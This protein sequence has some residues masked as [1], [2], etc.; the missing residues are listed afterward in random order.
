[1]ST[2]SGGVGG[3][4]TD[5]T[6]TSNDLSDLNHII[7][8]DT[9]GPDCHRITVNAAGTLVSTPVNC[10]TGPALPAFDNF[11]SYSA[12]DLTGANGGSG[13]SE[14]WQGGGHATFQV[15]TS[16]C[17]FGSCIKGSGG[18]VM[19][20]DRHFATTMSNGTLTFK[21]KTIIGG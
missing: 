12:G 3:T 18:S 9:D 13:W 14:A 11:D 4:I 21:T 1:S 8:K 2:V 17:Y 5:N 20:N 6:I 19:D 10:S 16:G 7:L 15:V